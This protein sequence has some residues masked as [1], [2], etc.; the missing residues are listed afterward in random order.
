[1]SNI[2]TALKSMG[3]RQPDPARSERWCKPI[4][5][6]MI[7]CD[8]EGDK[9]IFAQWMMGTPYKPKLLCWASQELEIKEKTSQRLITEICY[10]EENYTKEFAPPILQPFAFLTKMEQLDNFV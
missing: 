10:F 5:F 9:A 3:Y 4:G 8:V 6:T 1:M 7:N 2:K